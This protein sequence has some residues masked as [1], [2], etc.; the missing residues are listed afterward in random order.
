MKAD[1]PEFVSGCIVH[2]YKPTHGLII[3]YTLFS[4]FA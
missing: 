3:T 4:I 2:V 1:T